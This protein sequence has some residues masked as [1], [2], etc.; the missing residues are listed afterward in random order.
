MAGTEF[1]TLTSPSKQLWN[2][3]SGNEWCY[4]LTSALKGE[5]L[6]GEK[7]LRK[8]IYLTLDFGPNPTPFPDTGKKILASPLAET[9]SRKTELLWTWV[10]V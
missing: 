6:G 8:D 5:T 9:S 10:E 1:Q 7:S 2:W 4:Y 3:V